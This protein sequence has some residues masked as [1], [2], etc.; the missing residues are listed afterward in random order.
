MGDENIRKLTAGGDCADSIIKTAHDL[1]IDIIVLGS[2][3]MRWLE[4]ILMGS[5]TEK[6]M[7]HSKIPLFIIPTGSR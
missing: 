5:I 1:N 6:V 4:K 2:H 7:H 3:S